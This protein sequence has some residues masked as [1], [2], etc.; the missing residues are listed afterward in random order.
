MFY[1]ID[2]EDLLWLSF[3]WLG[4]TISTLYI[5]PS[6]SV[7]DLQ[8][9]LTTPDAISAIHKSDLIIGDFNMHIKGYLCRRN[10]ARA[11]LLMPTFQASRHNCLN[12]RTSHTFHRGQ[13]KTIID[14]LFSKIPAALSIKDISKSD[15][16]LLHVGLKRRAK[17]INKTIRCLPFYSEVIIAKAAQIYP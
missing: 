9:I 16:R 10:D 3:Y 2:T 17:S 6:T 11:N 4:F 12:N 1:S 8:R 14:F 15:H 5:P 13:S 7:V